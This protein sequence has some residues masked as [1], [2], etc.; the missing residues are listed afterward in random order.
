[1]L[2]PLRGGPS[3]ARCDELAFRSMQFL[4]REMLALHVVDGV[5]GDEPLEPGAH[6]QAPAGE[7][8][9]VAVAY[10]LAVQPGPAASAIAT[11]TARNSSAST[12]PIDAGPWVPIT[13]RA[14][15]ELGAWDLVRGTA[16]RRTL[17]ADGVRSTPA[18]LR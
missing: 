7:G 14:K 16:T 9:H 6:R 11:S 3:T 5:G 12:T 4:E 1:M 17:P 13:R 2:R 8:A 10:W 18:G 15:Q